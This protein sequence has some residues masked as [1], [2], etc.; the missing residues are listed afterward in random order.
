M[1]RRLCLAVV[2]AVTLVGGSGALFPAAAGAMPNLPVTGTWHLH[3]NDCF[4]GV[5]DYDL[6]LVQQGHQ[7]TG[8]PGSGMSGKVSGNT[9]EVDYT[10]VSSEDDWSCAGWLN[11]THTRFHGTFND[12]TGGTG[13]CHAWRT[14]P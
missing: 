12:G 11:V 9:I 6:H 1:I 7:L 3:T 8:D 4:F 10:G 2:V 14:G 13:K 5:C